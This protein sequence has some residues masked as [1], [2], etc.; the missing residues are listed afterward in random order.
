M[1]LGRQCFTH[2]Y[3]SNNWI[4]IKDHKNQEIEQLIKKHV[5]YTIYNIDSSGTTNMILSNIPTHMKAKKKYKFSN[6]QP[7]QRNIVIT[8]IPLI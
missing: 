2:V 8:V 7:K 4:K 1:C 3:N 6:G 5:Y